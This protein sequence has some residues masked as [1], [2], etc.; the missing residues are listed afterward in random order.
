MDTMVF[1][2]QE[3][4]ELKETMHPEVRAILDS[5]RIKLWQK[6]LVEANYT[7]MG[8]VQEFVQGTLLVGEVEQCGLWPSKFLPA[9][10]TE[11]ELL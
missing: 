3:E 1:R 11:S 8:V 5:K 6:L 2:V 7:D 10:I 4:C 9:L